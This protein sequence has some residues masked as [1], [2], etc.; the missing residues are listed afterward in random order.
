MFCKRAVEFSWVAFAVMAFSACS[1]LNPYSSDF[2]CPKGDPGKCQ[3]MRRSYEESFGPPKD[4][5]AAVK[6]GKGEKARKAGEGANG[7]SPPVADPVETTYRE[8]LLERFRELLEVPEPPVVAPAE[9]MRILILPY[10]GSDG[11][12][13]MGRYIYVFTEGPRWVLEDVR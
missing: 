8:Q 9:T 1:I 11:E 10:R 7:A 5:A 2:S 4:G 6:G 3:S 13:F 12:L